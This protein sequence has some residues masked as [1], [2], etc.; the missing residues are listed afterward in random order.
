MWHSV[1][2]QNHPVHLRK[3][4]CIL[5]VL[6]SPV[7]PSTVVIHVRGEPQNG[8]GLKL[9]FPCPED[10]FEVLE[11]H[12]A[13]I[14]LDDGRRRNCRDPVD[15]GAAHLRVARADVR[16][17][18]AAPTSQWLRHLSREML[19]VAGAHVAMHEP[20]LCDDELPHASLPRRATGQSGLELFA[21][22]DEDDRLQGALGLVSPGP[23]DETAAEE[24]LGALLHAV[25]VPGV[26]S[27]RPVHV[28]EDDLPEL[29]T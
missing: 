25:L 4:L 12:S 21:V 2:L 17:L 7:A 13:C 23:A 11:L 24:V 9:G 16:R 20:L 8:L 27:G 28:G 29:G 26:V 18:D 10:G 14:Q 5:G 6:I 19:A 15:D 3:L 22:G 1:H